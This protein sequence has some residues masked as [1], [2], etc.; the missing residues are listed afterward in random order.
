MRST[1]RPDWIA[2]V[3]ALLAFAVGCDRDRPASPPPPEPTAATST[4]ARPALSALPEGPWSE[5]MA[6]DALAVQRLALDR[7][8]DELLTV[9]RSD[10]EAW[11]VALRALASADDAEH[12]FEDLAS[13]AASDAERREAALVTLRAIATRRPE[14]V[15]VRDPPGLGAGAAIL[16]RLS[17]DDSLARR[18]RAIAISTLRGLARSGRWDPSAIA[19]LP[20][21]DAASP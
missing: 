6:G 19:S 18:H 3:S 20:A 2:I 12:V 15:E 8:V 7:D 5:A 21:A 1:I 16:D 9:A 13:L 17:R 4:A 14:P 10:A 11:A